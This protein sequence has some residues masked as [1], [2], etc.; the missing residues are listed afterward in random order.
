M[1]HKGLKRSRC[2]VIEH[3]SS[4]SVVAGIPGIIRRALDDIPRYHPARREELGSNSAEEFCWSLQTRSKEEPVS[5]PLFRSIFL[6]SSL[7]NSFT[8]QLR[9]TSNYCFAG[10]K[11]HP[12]KEFHR[13]L[14]TNRIVRDTDSLINPSW[15]FQRQ[16][17]EM[18]GIVPNGLV[19]SSLFSWVV[20]ERKIGRDRSKDLEIW[21]LRFTEVHWCGVIRGIIVRM[22]IRCG[23]FGIFFF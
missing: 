5:L 12:Q 20:K 8:F 6:S 10:Q 1:D 14:I 19:Q 2:K 23:K 22:R 7:S 11:G 16:R 13:I 17:L 4:S 3:D 9:S 15:I 18:A 21:K